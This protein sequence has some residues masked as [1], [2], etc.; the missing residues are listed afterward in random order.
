MNGTFYICRP[1]A[2]KHSSEL[3]RQVSVVDAFGV[4]KS[5]VIRVNFIVVAGLE[6][7]VSIGRKSEARNSRLPKDLH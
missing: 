5:Q 6:Q 7:P 1:T 2:V 4:V 3:E